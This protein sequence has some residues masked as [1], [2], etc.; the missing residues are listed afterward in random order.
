MHLS[1]TGTVLPPRLT[2]TCVPPP[3]GALQLLNLKQS[4]Y[5]LHGFA[6]C[7]AQFNEIKSCEKI[8]KNK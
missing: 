5:Y 1:V 6:S 4:D 3:E 8:A 2:M 7:H